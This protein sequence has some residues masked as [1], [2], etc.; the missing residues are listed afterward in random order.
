[1]KKLLILSLYLSFVT[2]L[3]FPQTYDEAIRPR[4]LEK[5]ER[6]TVALVLAG[7]GSRG[8]AHIPVIELIEELGIPIDMVIGTSAG[9]I[10]GGLYSAGYSSQEIADTMLDLNW[11]SLFQD[12]TTNSFE[13]ALSDHSIET[14]IL[15]MQLDDDLSLKLGRGLLTGQSVYEFFKSITIKIPSYIHF[16]SLITP[17]RATAVDL[18][19]GEMVVIQQ[20]DL[21]EAIRA[22]MSIPAVFE[23]FEIDGRYYMDGFTRNNMPVQVAHDM[24]YDII[25]AVDL[26]EQLSYNVND[27]NSNPLE[28]LNQV[29]ALQQLV[30][31]DQEYELADLVI[32][33]DIYEFG[34]IDYAH[35]VDIYNKGK[36][37][38]EQYRQSLIDLRTKI[39]PDFNESYNPQV[40]EDKGADENSYSFTYIDNELMLPFKRSQNYKSLKNLSVDSIELVNN[41]AADKAFI[42][43]KFESIRN[44]ALTDKVV[45]NFL[46]SIYERGHYVM[47]NARVDMRQGKG[48]LVLDFIQKD[49]KQ[50]LVTIGGNFEGSLYDTTSAVLN[51]STALQFR[52]LGVNGAIISIK[53]NVIN[54]TGIEA[55][56]VQP[57]NE[58][59]FLNVKL[60]TNSAVDVVSSGWK[61]HE[62][63]GSQVNMA[64]FSFGTGIFFSNEHK[65]FNA[66][67]LNWYDSSQIYEDSLRKY[68]TG[69]HVNVHYTADALLRYA[70]STLDYMAFPTSGFYNDL[71]IWGVLPL[72]NEKAP[73]AFDVV[74][75]NFL[76][77]LP[78]SS[79]I[80]LVINSFIGT[81]ITQELYKIPSLIP[82][83]G[84]TTYDRTF[85]PQ[86]PSGDIFGIHKAALKLDVQF[87]IPGQL[88]L[89]G[90][91]PFVG[92]SGSTGN[93]WD[94]YD[95]FALFSKGL[96]WQ[97]SAFA[98]IRI[99][100]SVGVI[101]RVGAG[102][103]EDIRS[104]FISID[105]FTKHY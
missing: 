89:I 42:L 26:T 21:A 50:T 86:I 14:N 31:V 27:F 11:V 56:Y 52:G 95:S 102:S 48:S 77:A 49:K 58:K 34:Q 39:F 23:P 92:F 41:V 38:V 25:I 72:S 37:E 55:L 94:T 7:G 5:A 105:F 91:Q 97:T 84:Y 12:S 3:I 79:N 98:G 51:L 54:T 104:P 30:V 103:S 60:G 40:Y 80:S 61:K 22:S 28:V 59:V 76:T 24:G 19:T 13:S 46:Q 83:Y 2:T 44:E 81:N 66:I 96:E 16:D 82:K 71:K 35:S 88:T 64:G 74:E 15:S 69:E 4:D 8:F 6:P 10:I 63:F 45:S 36:I 20:G 43:N 93:V 85:F 70:F 9:A 1:M 18:L 73:I 57:L 47:V 100:D 32:A 75:T 33:P 90:G 101:L 99:K 17:F 53:G 62:V 29:T 78:L 65:L 87:M 68:Y 67:G